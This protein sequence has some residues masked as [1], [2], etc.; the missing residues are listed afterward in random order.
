M[1][2]EFRTKLTPVSRMLL[3]AALASCG[4]GDTSQEEEI[5]PEQE[6]QR[7]NVVLITLDTTRADRIGSY[8][9]EPA[10]TET[11]DAIASRGTR[12]ANTYAPMPLTIP[13]HST[14]FT[15]LN[16]FNHGVRSNSTS[17]L[18]DEYT[19]LAEILKDSGYNTA[20]SVAAFV[21]SESWGF[22]Q[23]FDVYLDDIPRDPSRSGHNEW[24]EE[25]SANLVVDDAIR[26][27]EQG[28]DV[29]SSAFLWVH[30]FDPHKPMAA[31]AEYRG[32]GIRPYDAEIAFVDDQIQR[33]VDVIGEEDTV[34]VVAGDHGEGHGGHVETEHGLFL[35]NGTQRVP[36]FMA[37][38]GIDV[39]VVEESVGLV[40]LLPTLLSTLDIEV[41]EGLDGT[42][43]P[44]NPHPIYMETYQLL[45]R[46]GYSPHVAVVDGPW[47]LIDTPRPEL[48]NQVEDIRELNN[49]AESEPERVEAMRQLLV[50]F[51]A[52]PPGEASQE[53][54]PE[55]LAR[56]AALGY[57]SGGELS[58]L[59][60]APDPK[61]RMNVIQLLQQADR[62]RRAGEG[63]QAD[64]LLIEA[65]AEDPALVE[66]RL[67][68][69][70][71]LSESGDLERARIYIDEAI[72][73]RTSIM[74]L[75]LATMIYGR[76]GDHERAFSFAQQG[77]DQEP[78]NPQAVELLLTAMVRQGQ[79]ADA[80]TLAIEF[81]DTHPDADGIAGFIGIVLAEQGRYEEAQLLLRQGM[82]ATFPR[83]KMRQHMAMIA[84][85]SGE[86]V[87]AIELLREELV[88]YADNDTARKFL[89]R[90]LEEELM[91]EE[92][93]EQV[94]IMLGLHPEDPKLHHAK[95][96]VLF[97]LEDMDGCEAVL[98]V[99]LERFEGHPELLLLKA[100]LLMARGQ[101]EAGHAVFAEA[102]A[103]LQGRE[104][105]RAALLEAAEAAA[106][107]QEEPVGV[108]A[109]DVAAE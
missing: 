92:Q 81:L 95:A 21:T 42:V 64:N 29:E 59:E 4:G 13:S 72:D 57:V 39:S 24:K 20:A 100:N 103:A 18:E 3:F 94:E 37:G 11:L 102:Q 71:S 85:S 22:R 78:D 106:Q 60:G 45:E 89:I 31:P 91:Y 76:L 17:I 10:R 47:K 25:R 109:P 27:W 56:L 61:D 38:P 53:F 52:S 99:A 36:F 80:E 62:A 86:R 98:E 40:D 35:Y 87:D 97:N 101:T 82:N 6:V 12:F 54:D 26:W 7:P 90:L 28:R 93:L 77:V 5:Q 9:Y 30:L 84:Y 70:R 49:L 88:D 48:Y 74:V 108:V 8:G 55:T 73:H 50:D 69:V 1:D 33:L 75:Q 44:G 14:M 51:G 19:T 104:A 58:D 105:A 83:R 68:L 23:G 16:P 107:A 34:W 96:Q 41:P 79:Y 66:A 2:R 67:K 63:E 32:E 46:F 43:Q 65:L 15:G